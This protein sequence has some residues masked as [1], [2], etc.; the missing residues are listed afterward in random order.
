MIS[1]S[2]RKSL[3]CV[4]IGCMVFLYGC[5]SSGAAGGTV[6][7]T[8]G[9]AAGVQNETQTV[10]GDGETATENGDA[11]GPSYSQNGRQFEILEVKEKYLLVSAVDM[12]YGLYTAG[13][14][15]V[16]EDEDG[17]A[18]Q[19]SDLEPGMIVE[20]TWNGMIQESY[21]GQFSYDRLRLTGRT[22]S[23]ELLLYQQII[24][25][26]AKKD[27]GLNDGIGECYFDFTGVS[28][29]TA[30]EKEGLAYRGGSSFGVFGSQATAEELA[31]AGILDRE[32]GIENGL[33]VTI[34]EISS[35]G[36]TVK[37]NAK[38]Y[39][40]GTGAYYLSDITAVYSDGE[41]SY[42]IGSEAIS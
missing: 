22:G 13:H 12:A 24:K 3:G 37:C 10:S 6:N 14:G 9:T 16:L 26:L 36:D 33:L 39:R 8:A 38:K 18:I 5:G 2:V 19:V 1:S 35:E 40:S 4:L 25:E 41:W 20:L 17:N 28:S 7:E 15:P 42:N 34:E 27:S 31:E 11:D 29:L 32:K 30:A 23:R 21:P